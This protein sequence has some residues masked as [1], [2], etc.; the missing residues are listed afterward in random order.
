MQP[1]L[2]R[3]TLS[4][5]SAAAAFCPLCAPAARAAETH[6]GPL[7]WSYRGKTGPSHWSELSADFKTCSLGSA[8][9]PIDLRKAEHKPAGKLEIAFQPVGGRVLNNGHTIQVNTPAGSRTVIGDTTYELLQFHFHHPSEHLLSG[10]HLDMEI[11]FVHRAANGALAV[12]GSFIKPGA[13]NITL[14]PIWAAMP[15]QEGEQAFDG[16]IDP[17]RLLP[18]ERDYFRYMGSLTTPPCSEGLSWTVFRAPVEAS[19]AQIKQFAALF[20]HN[21]RP[22]Q[23]LNGRTLVENVG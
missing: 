19:D 12:L 11:H 20:P 16:T 8:Q 21:A 6:A 2:S 3:R 9:T 17:S 13:A 18:G 1:L 10:K 4:G 15:K 5:F 7:H 14:A 23:K 22:V